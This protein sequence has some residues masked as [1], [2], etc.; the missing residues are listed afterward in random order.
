MSKFEPHLS[1]LSVIVN[2]I[3]W[4]PDY[5]KLADANQLR[6]LFDADAMPKLITVGYLLIGRTQLLMLA[7]PGAV[8]R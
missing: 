5:P 7:H 2:G 4:T 3:F 6:S 8:S 1:M